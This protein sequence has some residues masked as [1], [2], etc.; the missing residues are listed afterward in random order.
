MSC[1]QLLERR[2]TVFVSTAEN[3]LAAEH[4]SSSHVQQELE[5]LQA[6]WAMLRSQV[7]ESKRLID[8]SVQYFIL[9]EEVRVPAVRKI[10]GW[11]NCNCLIVTCSLKETGNFKMS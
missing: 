3:L 8:L 6:R 10:I 5:R 2:V 9:V 4:M 11:L 7:T 1:T